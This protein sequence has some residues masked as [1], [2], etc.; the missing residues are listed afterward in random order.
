MRR[1]SSLLE[2]ERGIALVMV[3]WVLA[4][5][6]LMAVSFLAEARV[7]L[8]R[9]GNLRERAEAEALAE[10]GIHIATARLIA[11]HGETRPQRWRESL[12]GGSVLLTIASE[13]GKIDLNEAEPELLSGLFKSQGLP[14]SVASALT[15]AIVDFRD[16]D[17]DSGLEGAEDADYPAGSGGA[18]DAYFETIDEVL[19]VKGMTP[20]LYAR[21]APLVTVHSTMPVVDPG[22]ADPGVL[23]AVPG[24]DRAELT[25]FLALRAELA[26]I[27]NAPAKAER[28]GTPGS[29]Q[30]RVKALAQL[31]AAVPQR[32]SVTRFFLAENLAEPTLTISAEA[33]TATGA[34]FRREAVLRLNEDSS[35]PFDLLEWR[36]PQALD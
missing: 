4:L 20:A 9:A 18:K 32:N 28:A 29:T 34:R 21:I 25:R 19:Q 31:Q 17:H 27:L 26:P 23:A 33:I 3:I 15:A 22:V 8:R 14:P 16:A 35:H 7:E 12:A 30:Q 6:S 2:D 5:L 36:R 11:E 24:I 1:Q 13:Y 10:A